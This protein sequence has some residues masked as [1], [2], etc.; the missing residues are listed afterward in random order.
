MGGDCRDY[1]GEIRYVK[2]SS[3]VFLLILTLIQIY[4]NIRKYREYQKDPQKYTPKLIKLTHT[5]SIFFIILAVA[6]LVWIIL[7]LV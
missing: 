2:F 6:E 7:C 1:H 3:D 5:I 4:S